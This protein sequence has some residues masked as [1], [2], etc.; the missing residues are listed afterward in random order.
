MSFPCTVW[1][2]TYG[3]NIIGM[4]DFPLVTIVKRGAKAVGLYLLP[5]P[6]SSGTHSKPFRR[7][8]S[9]LLHHPSRTR[10]WQ[11]HLCPSPQAAPDVHEG[12]SYRTPCR[13]RHGGPAAGLQQFCLHVPP[14][15]LA[16]PGAW[17]P[18]DGLGDVAQSSVGVGASRDDQGAPRLISGGVVG[19]EVGER[20]LVAHRLVEGVVAQTFAPMPKHRAGNRTA[21]D[22]QDGTAHSAPSWNPTQPRSRPRLRASG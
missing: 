2:R 20:K 22:R 10:E 13:S 21:D 19:V 6:L 8:S 1:S 3:A 7:L 12:R 15:G 17:I 9:G 14:V 18:A 11:G 16:N 5:V 4:P